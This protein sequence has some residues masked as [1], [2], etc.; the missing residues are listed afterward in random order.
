MSSDFDVG[1]LARLEQDLREAPM[2]VQ[3]KLPPVVDRGAVNIKRDWRASATETA[4]QHGKLYPSSIDFDAGWVSGGYE[5]EIGPRTDR[6]QGGMGP[7]FEYGSVHQQPHMD[8]NRAADA[9]GPRFERAVADLIDGV[10]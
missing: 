5:A 9:E 6:P 3:R 7:G 2:R 1:E 8:G 4:G 10:L